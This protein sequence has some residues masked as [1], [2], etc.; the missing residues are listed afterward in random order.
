MTLP[1]HVGEMDGSL[2]T[3]AASAGKQVQ[4]V[5]RDRRGLGGSPPG[6]SARPA[7]SSSIQLR[8]EVAPQSR[9]PMVFLWV[10]IQ[11]DVAG[12]GGDREEGGR[13]SSLL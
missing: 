2:G 13:Q 10:S 5:H 11:I 3:A 4:E 9:S 7:G 6:K 12:V 8:L 1:G